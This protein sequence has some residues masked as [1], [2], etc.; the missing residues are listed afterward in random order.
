PDLVPD[1]SVVTPGIGPVGIPRTFSFIVEN[2]GTV[3]ERYLGEAESQFRID[4]DV[5]GE[6]GASVLSRPISRNLREVLPGQKVEVEMQNAWVPAHSGLYRI[7]ADLVYPTDGG[8]DDPRDNRRIVKHRVFDVILPEGGANLTTEFEPD[9]ISLWGHN[10]SRYATAA[11]WSFTPDLEYPD[12]VDTTLTLERVLN[13]HPA[14]H[15]FLLLNH[16]YDFERSYDGGRLEASLDGG[17]LWTTMNPIEPGGFERM[18]TAS[19]FVAD[20][21]RVEYAFTGTGQGLYGFNLGDLPDLHTT[22]TLLEDDFEKRGLPQLRAN[23]TVGPDRSDPPVP[24][25]FASQPFAASFTPLPAERAPYVVAVRVEPLTGLGIGRVEV[26][27]DGSRWT[28]MASEGGGTYKLHFP[29]DLDAGD[30]QME[31]D[32]LL[33]AAC[34]GNL[35]AMATCHRQVLKAGSIVRFRVFSDVDQRLPYRSGAYSWVPGVSARL[36][37]EPREMVYKADPGQQVLWS[38]KSGVLCPA[39][40]TTP[41][42]PNL[43]GSNCMGI[44]NNPSDVNPSP[45]QTLKP[46]AILTTKWLETIVD[47][48]GADPKTSGVLRLDIRDWAGVPRT[49]RGDLANNILDNLGQDAQNV[50][51]TIT[52]SDGAK[53]VRPAIVADFAGEE[54][55]YWNWTDRVVLVQGVDWEKV[56]G[57][58]LTVRLEHVVAA[59]KS[60]ADALYINSDSATSV[61][62]TDEHSPHFGWGIA[63]AR[64]TASGSNLGGTRILATLT[65]ATYSSPADLRTAGWRQGADTKF[66]APALSNTITVQDVDDLF[67]LTREPFARGF[68]SEASTFEFDR[69]LDRSA[70]YGYTGRV[71]H[72]WE[73]NASRAEFEQTGGAARLVLPVDLKPAVGATTLTFNT[74]YHF[75]T[76]G[77]TITGKGGAAGGRVEV[78]VDDG[79]T[80]QPLTPKPASTPDFPVWQH[81]GQVTNTGGPKTDPGATSSYSNLLFYGP[82]GLGT[83]SRFLQDTHRDV[84]AASEFGVPHA[85]AGTQAPLVFTGAT[86]GAHQ[87]SRINLQYEPEPG[88]S[89]RVRH[90]HKD[91]VPVA[92]DLTEY[93]GKDVLIGFHASFNTRRASSGTHPIFEGQSYQDWWRVDDVR[94]QSEVLQGTD[95]RLRL[96]AATDGTVGAGGWDIRDLQVLA[97]KHLLNM[98][99]SVVSPTATEDLRLGENPIVVEVGNRGLTGVEDVRVNVWLNITGEGA[100]ASRVWSGPLSEFQGCAGAVVPSDSSLAAEASVRVCGLAGKTDLSLPGQPGAKYRLEVLA[101]HRGFGDELLVADNRVVREYDG[102]RV[103][104][105]S[106]V[107]AESIVVRPSV[108]EPRVE[109][110]ITATARLKLVGFDRADVESATLKVL[111]DPTRPFELTLANARTFDTRFLERGEVRDLVFD[112]PKDRVRDLPEGLY[113]VE[114]TVVTASAVKRLESVTT[115]PLLVTSEMRV[116]PGF[117]FRETAATAE[118]RMPPPEPP[119]PSGSGRHLDHREACPEHPRDEAHDWCTYY[120]PEHAETEAS[121]NPSVSMDANPAHLMELWMVRDAVPMVNGVAPDSIPESA[122][123]RGKVLDLAGAENKAVCVDDPSGGQSASPVQKCRDE[124]RG[125]AL[126]SPTI[127]IRG[128]R[129]LNGNP[130][131]GV[132]F[133]QRYDFGADGAYARVL[134]AA[135]DW[136]DHQL[137]QHGTEVDLN[138]SNDAAIKE[139]AEVARFGGASPGYSDFEYATFTADVSAALDRARTNNK[140]FDFVKVKVVLYVPEKGRFTGWQIDDLTVGP[141]AATLRPYQRIPVNDDTDK[142]YKYFLRNGGAYSDTY[143]VTLRKS[144]GAPTDLPTGWNVT[145][146]DEDGA[147]LDQLGP[148]PATTDRCKAVAGERR[149]TIGLAAGEE[150]LLGLKVCIPVGSGSPGRQGFAPIQV[151]AFSQ[152]LPG[153]QAGSNA[154]LDY[155]YLNRA[156]L[157]VLAVRPGAD[158]PVDQPRQVTVEIQNSGTT[159]ACEA[160]ITVVDL[161]A[162][163]APVEL[164]APDGSTPTVGVCRKRPDGVVDGGI[165]P[166]EARQFRFIWTPRTVGWHNLTATADPL[167]DISELLEDDNQVALPV[168]VRLPSFP[169]LRVRLTVSDEEPNIGDAVRISAAITNLGGISAQSVN[170]T[171]KV[172]VTDLFGRGALNE[173]LVPR[174]EPG[175]TVYVNKTWRAVFPGKALLYVN[176]LPRDG[177]LERVETQANNLV[178]LPLFVRSQGLDVAAKAV[179]FEASPGEAK[180]VGFI[181]SNNGD[182]PDTYDI[183]VDAPRGVRASVFH[184]GRKISGLSLANKT[185]TNLTVFL[186]LP[187]KVEAGDVPIGLRA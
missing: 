182:T 89:N 98:G 100:P 20:P 9:D 24:P 43:A 93:A 106:Q 95:V 44:S 175:E 162:G 168:L 87:Q 176:A 183:T 68:W 99:V 58:T 84:G 26:T 80:W 69:P 133:L 112:L 101:D 41:A 14:R 104:A 139:W 12:G 177:V 16:S 187:P 142:T 48:R 158:L 130:R 135:W 85:S 4:V 17:R 94:V 164:L 67:M 125:Y 81:E 37:D 137:G 90:D 64:V 91:W 113:T 116:S 76:A 170:V 59:A 155:T 178:V 61:R 186:D 92:F 140:T 53:I 28:A 134:A 39:E 25:R 153:V 18:S 131:I 144:N 129:G 29:T 167:G 171:M 141:F 110:E 185:S 115:A 32:A 33:D 96:R 156:N 181:V 71:N 174:I 114:L 143:N 150:R 10:A 97:Q 103:I 78:S 138:D 40:A 30:R 102:E 70:P 45:P 180:D 145:I 128:M 107:K 8:E 147:I 165:P 13:L 36:L 54:D 173:G 148:A 7:V 21:D 132:S 152:T 62:E 109:R 111:G 75:G 50:R 136:G 65:P 105:T 22:T 60:G 169:D 172:G 77:I 157:R 149:S 19:P 160:A 154:D 23:L 72:F 5:F 74:Q 88:K 63:S 42:I 122:R 52:A 31:P 124:V 11:G 118:I 159:A 34:T 146:L 57:K 15:A 6:D 163:E 117:L 179:S 126:E 55:R 123:A 166:G 46:G 2:R 73:A 51:L 86:P 127:D 47:L 35:S 151:T 161:Q 83:A 120:Q 119:Q 184:E 27:V 82:L 3:P 38:D 79:L 1:A 49:Y 56:A 66:Y 108:T 121:E